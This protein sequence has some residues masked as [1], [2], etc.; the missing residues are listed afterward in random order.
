METSKFMGLDISIYNTIEKIKEWVEHNDINEPETIID[1]LTSTLRARENKPLKPTLTH[2][3]TSEE[4]Y[5]YS[6]R[7][8]EWEVEKEQFE[9]REKNRFKF[10]DDLNTYICQYIWEE[11]G[12]NRLPE[13]MKN[14]VWSE[15][16]ERVDSSV[17]NSSKYMVLS[18]LVELIED[19]ISFHNE[20]VQQRLNVER[21]GDDTRN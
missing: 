20:E 7:L 16:C 12:L 15:V 14:R 10:N 8:K 13:R 19:S 2:S 5:A 6:Q 1:I 11:A 17:D 21:S 4:A 3:H 18:N 9:F